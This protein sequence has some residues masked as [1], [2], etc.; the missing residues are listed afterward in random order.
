MRL[1]TVIL[2]QRCGTI[3]FASDLYYRLNVFPIKIPPL[4]ERPE[5][6][7][8]LVESF[9]NEFA[10]AFGKSIESIDKRSIDALRIYEWPGNIR[11][12]RNTVERALILANSSRLQIRAP[13]PTNSTTIS[14]AMEDIEREHLRKVLEM[15]GWRIRGKDGAAEI[16][17]VKPTTLESRI[18]RFNLLR[19]N[20]I[21]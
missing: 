15:T 8:Q 21:N 14:L 6:I 11:E 3:L 13:K 10:K 2:R 16:L 12:L 9:V 17:G 7:P 20:A 4:R 5:D 19:K 1:Q 18:A